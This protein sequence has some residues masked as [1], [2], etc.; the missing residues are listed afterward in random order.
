MANTATLT[1]AGFETISQNTNID[2]Q[3][4][5][6]TVNLQNPSTATSTAGLT[7]FFAMLRSV[8][9]NSST[10]RPLFQPF[11]ALD[12]AGAA[13]NFSYLSISPRSTSGAFT[14]NN[15]SPVNTPVPI[16]ANG[17]APDNFSDLWYV[18]IFGRIRTEGSS[19]SGSTIANV[20]P[21]GIMYMSYLRQVDN[22]QT[23][24]KC[25]F[26]FSNQS[27]LSSIKFTYSSGNFFGLS[28]AYSPLD[29][30]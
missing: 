29:R 24:G 14:S 16:V 7:Y 21:S 28:H 23:I 15:V 20:Y 9:T 25:A 17:Q 8:N 11:Q 30:S 12:A 3:R 4:S 13:N 5:S 27:R 10:L 26:T 2:T 1:S 6:M 18:R 19:A 22:T